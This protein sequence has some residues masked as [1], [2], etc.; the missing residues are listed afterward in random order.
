MGGRI[1]ILLVEDSEDDAAL[2]ARALVRA[3]L[4][5]ETERVES[6]AAMRAAL[7]RG[8]F[9]V[10][11]SDYALPGW[12]ALEAL[13]IQR[14]VAPDLPFLIVSGAIGEE[15]AVSA[16]RAGADDYVMKGQLTRL[17]AAVERAL[18]DA[19][20]RRE[21][22]A[23][24]AALREQ[25]DRIASILASMVD[26][27]WSTSADGERVL[28]VSPS[29]EALSGGDAA[30]FHARPIVG[31]GRIV[32][33][34]Q[35]RVLSAHAA[36]R[37]SGALDV[38]YRL[39]LP[40]GQMRWIHDRARLVRGPDG[41]PLRVDGIA[42][43]VTARRSAE[44]RL[45]AIVGSAMDAIVSVD[46]SFHV[47][48]WNRAAE[49]VFG[50]K[51]AEALGKPLETFIPER[52]RAEHH[53][54]MERF[55]GTGEATRQLGFGPLVGLR[56]DGTE[57]PMEASISRVDAEG[58]L[59]TVILRDIS[60]R[61]E[62]ERERSRL[63][64]QLEH[65]QKLDALGR[66]AGGIAHDF[67]NIL[68][69]ILGLVESARAEIDPGQRAHGD[70]GHVL[71]ACARARDLVRQILAF[72]RRSE[73]MR[74][75]V[76]L[77]HVVEDAMRLL[78]ASLPA[79]VRIDASRVEDVPLVLAD[80]SQVHQVITNL[81]TNAFDAM[82]G[83]SG[84]IEIGLEVAYPEPD[85]AAAR[86]RMWRGPCVCLSVRDDGA[87]MDSATVRKI[88]EPFFTTKPPG[89]GTGL[90]LAMVHGIVES[91]EGAIA[92]DSEPGKGSVFRIYLPIQPQLAE[93]APVS[94]PPSRQGHGE[95]VLVVDDE[96]LI[97]SSTRRVL[98]RLGYRVTTATDPNAAL[99]SFRAHPTDYDAL[100]IDLTMPGMSGTALLRATR[101]IRPLVPA[102]LTT[103]YVGALAVEEEIAPDVEVLVK[104]A[105][106]EALAGALERVLRNRD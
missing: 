44:T 99:E 39:L 106:T 27:V 77:R 65:A 70:L 59:F 22:R 10:V 79:S 75:P 33:E 85:L 36:L 12:G 58:G 63:E 26:V 71:D 38:E 76:A 98:S 80:P 15:V 19:Q 18:R 48:V 30:A 24:E 7:A 3:G 60:A 1:R 46:R 93:S 45:A 78:R 20:A 57:F 42:T 55:R 94:S 97:C 95:H 25:Q 4:M 103:G 35:P 54:Y 51:E 49:R 52:Y 104:P 43:D 31:F 73:P 105:S 32:P 100:L 61:L 72:S 37:Q 50:W 68:G 102:V 67:N 21:R 87:G 5:I 40:D 23:A 34:D 2:I 17:P 89:K 6:T 41:E 86:P 81:L 96:A 14:E 13:A 90:G 83:A 66:L 53:R 92:V 8:G 62:A 11:V 82:P 16:M 9:D 88:F 74:R 56:A 47:V 84:A 64:A 69:G 91:H 28:F 29:I 101:E